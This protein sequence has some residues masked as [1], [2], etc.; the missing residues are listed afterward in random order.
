MQAQWYVIQS[1]PRQEVKACEEL[2]KQGYE[3]YLPTIMKEKVVG[4][5]RVQKE[6]ALFS[7]YLFI[8]L[9]QTDSNWG[10]L[11]STR[12]VSGMVRFGSQIPSLSSEQLSAIRNWVEHLPKKDCFTPGQ[13]LEVIAGPFRGMQGI[14]E[15]LVKTANGE[16]RAIV[17]FELL[18]KTQQISS[19][20]A[21]LR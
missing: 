2:Q 19:P 4:G 11:R 14:F 17:L 10:P 18:G 1:K 16:E 3:V 13:I 8:H 6:E 5:Q 12:G 20:L 21:D 15:K 7:R 9:D